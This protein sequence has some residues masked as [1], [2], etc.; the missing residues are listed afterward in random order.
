M[1]TTGADVAGRRAI[2]SDLDAESSMDD[3][4]E[5][6]DAARAARRAQY[7]REHVHRQQER[8]HALV[9]LPVTRARGSRPARDSPQR[10]SPSTTTS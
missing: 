1:C 4:E 2:R 8:A 9:R 6:A 5:W 10:A 7:G 3:Y